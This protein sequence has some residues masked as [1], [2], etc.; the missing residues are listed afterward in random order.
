MIISKLFV[1]SLFFITEILIS[2]IKFRDSFC[3]C[4]H[5]ASV[6]LFVIVFLFA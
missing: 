5:F 6:G 4:V 2:I 3:V 1:N